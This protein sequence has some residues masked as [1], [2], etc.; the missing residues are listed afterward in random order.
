MQK[1]LLDFLAVNAQEENLIWD[2]ARHFYIAQWYRDI[3]YQRRRVAEGD[4]RY[5]S[6]KKG[7]IKQKDRKGKFFFIV[8]RIFKILNIF[9]KK[10]I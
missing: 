4:K 6:R 5:A 7:N 9:K 10:Y 2:Y 1:I 8:L 3:I